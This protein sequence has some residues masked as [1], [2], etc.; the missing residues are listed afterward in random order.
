VNHSV[1][2]CLLI[3]GAHGIEH[4]LQ[5]ICRHHFTLQLTQNGNGVAV[6]DVTL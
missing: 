6:W 1:L 5:Q 2:F 4:A 3:D